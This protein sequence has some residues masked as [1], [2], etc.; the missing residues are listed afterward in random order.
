MTLDELETKYSECILLGGTACPDK[1]DTLALIA[2]IKD[3]QGAACG[4]CCGFADD[5]VM[6][7]IMDRHL[8][9]L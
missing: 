7:A 6:G 5:E 3:M 8:G 9:G 4:C 1:D 2:C